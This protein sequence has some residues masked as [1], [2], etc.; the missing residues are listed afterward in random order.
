MALAHQFFVLCHQKSEAGEELW[1]RPVVAPFT[2]LEVELEILLHAVKLCQAAFCNA[3]ESFDTVD[4]DRFFRK[5]S[6]F[7]D[8]EMFVGPTTSP[9]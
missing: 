2:L 8:A 5:L 1:Q 4:V 9:P 3:P 7:V 6:G